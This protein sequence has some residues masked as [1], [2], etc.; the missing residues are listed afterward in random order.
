MAI[1]GPCGSHCH[2]GGTFT[3]NSSTVKG[4][5]NLGVPGAVVRF[6]SSAGASNYGTLA[7]NSSGVFSGTISIPGTV[8]VHWTA[9]PG[10]SDPA[11]ARFASFGDH[12]FSATPGGSTTLSAVLTAAAG[13]TC[14]CWA[15]Y[16]VSATLHLTDS[17]LGSYT[18]THAGN[19]WTGGG[20]ASYG[21]C[22][23]GGC[24]AGSV[25][26]SYRLF[27][28]TQTTNCN[29]VWIAY[30]TDIHSCP[31]TG[32]VGSYFGQTSSLSG[33]NSWPLNLTFT[34][35]GGIPGALYCTFPPFPVWTVTE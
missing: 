12:T 16:P 32:A 8:T 10:A 1:R 4:C 15:Y 7:A 11:A 13:F 26:L 14:S 28:A 21:G 31:T 27:D 24:A 34:C 17:I 22:A 25:S 30:A 2:C 3:I 9:A 35:T 18:L 19:N 20:T 29:T 23:G 5:N 33:T 6:G